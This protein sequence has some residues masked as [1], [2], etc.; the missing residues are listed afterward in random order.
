[1]RLNR[2]ITIPMFLLLLALVLT[3]I[4]AASATLANIKKTVYFPSASDTW[5]IAQYPYMWT[6]GDYIEGTRTL[7][8]F[9]LLK[10]MGIHVVL[11]YNSL[12]T[13]YGEV[14]I[15]VYV[16][17]NRVGSLVVRPGDTT[18][19]ASLSFKTLCKGGVVTIEFLETNT[20]VSGYGSV[21]ISSTSST[22][23][24]EGFIIK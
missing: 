2:K 10:G 1:M 12:K 20:V 4:G 3:P 6:Q 16:N 9:A 8:S 22:V 18:V 17:G 14:D 23:T 7:G 15:D 24:F 19:D 13:P 21:T 11:S 5:S